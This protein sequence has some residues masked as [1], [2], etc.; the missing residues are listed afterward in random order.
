MGLAVL[1]KNR[2]WV[3]ITIQ[4][5]EGC[6]GWLAGRAGGTTRQKGCLWIQH[7]VPVKR[8]RENAHQILEGKQSGMI[9]SA[10]DTLLFKLISSEGLSWHH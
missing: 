1:G 2:K 10:Q 7:L 3:L 8:V 9:G 4:V 6:A 5:C